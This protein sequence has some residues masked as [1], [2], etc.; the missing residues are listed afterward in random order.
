MF[1]LA[2]DPRPLVGF[3]AVMISTG[4]QGDCTCDNC[5]L[6]RVGTGNVE[7]AALMAPRALGLTGAD[8]WTRDIM[9][10]GFP[11]LKQHYEMLGAGD[12]VMARALVQFQHNYNY[13]SREVMY[14]WFNKHL[15][16]RLSEPVVEEDYRP[17][18]IAEMSVWDADH[19]RPAGGE[20]YE[21]QL[22][23]WMT[24]DAAA[25]MAAL[26]PHDSP[27]LARYR[28]VVGGAIDAIVGRELPKAGSIESAQLGSQDRGAWQ[29]INALLR[30]PAEEEELPVIILRPKTWNRRTVVWLSE[31]GKAELYGD[32]GQLVAEAR[33]LLDAG[34]AIVAPDL[35]YQG[36]FLEPGQTMPEMRQAKNSRGYVGFT[37]GYNRALCA[38]APTMCCRSSHGCAMPSRCGRTPWGYWL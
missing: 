6:L 8:D 3:P 36:E 22:L 32:D 13:V 15:Q 9:T 27:S 4:M 5:S 17:L 37:L 11:R 38:S 12:K 28:E 1:L 35:L 18:T 21:R 30:Y 7:F 10:K 25:Q 24:K 23:V 29:E 14:Q 20:D 26:T 34:T 16:M 19:P 2:V 33:K 31:Q